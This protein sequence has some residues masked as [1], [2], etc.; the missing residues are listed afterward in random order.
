MDARKDAQSWGHKRSSKWGP[1]RLLW[2]W[3]HMCPRE[4][5][6]GRGFH[7]STPT[8][9]ISLIHRSIPS[10]DQR[11]V[12]SYTRRIPCKEDKNVTKMRGRPDEGLLFW[13]EPRHGH[14]PFLLG[15]AGQGHLAQP[16][17]FQGIVQVTEHMAVWRMY[18]ETPCHI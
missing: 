15:Q 14:A 13:H 11:L 10:K 4:D 8:S 1:Q 7:R 12:I 9:S 2:G 16:G 3:K 5:D 6:H 17:I 18:C